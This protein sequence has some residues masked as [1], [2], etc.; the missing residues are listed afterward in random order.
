MKI[1]IIAQGVRMP[2]WVNEAVAEYYKRLPS[3]LAPKITELPVL[4][5]DKKNKNTERNTQ[6]IPF[7]FERIL[8][9]SVVY[10]FVFSRGRLRPVGLRLSLYPIPNARLP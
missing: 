4:T 1:E 2:N 3:N 8:I 6:V 5:R 9:Q 10:S 7:I